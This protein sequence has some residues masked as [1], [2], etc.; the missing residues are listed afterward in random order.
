MAPSE[1]MLEARDPGG[2]PRHRVPRG[3]RRDRGRALGL[4]EH[5][6]AGGPIVVVL[7]DNI[8]QDP[9]KEAVLRCRADPVGAMILLKEFDDPERFGVA[10]L[11]GKLEITDVNNRYIQAGTMKHHWVRGWWTDA[12][13]VPSPHC[14]IDLVARGRDNPI[15]TESRGWR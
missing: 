4:A 12:G 1:V 7:G 9:I 2:R 6:A 15:L 3:T 5:F 10:K 14:A 11:Q 8:Y 13:R